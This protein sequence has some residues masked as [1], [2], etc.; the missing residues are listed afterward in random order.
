MLNSSKEE[1]MSNKVDDFE[2]TRILVETLIPFEDTDK[3]RI[4]RWACEKLGISVIRQSQIQNSQTSTN[5]KQPPI[6]QQHVI[7]SS[8]NKGGT[9]VDIKTFVNSKNPASDMQFATT[10]AYY[11]AFEAPDDQRKISISSQDLQDSCRLL[12]RERLQNPGQTLRN[13][14]HNG[15]LDKAEEKGAY[16]INTVG[17]N[18]VAVTLPGDSSTSKSRKL[19]KRKKNTSKKK[20]IKK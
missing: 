4:V 11:F 18:L 8:Q 12:G 15:L 13:T 20:T 7:P 5:L 6:E 1:K 9:P 10:I 17:E 14:H 3:E 19:P 2:A 16:K